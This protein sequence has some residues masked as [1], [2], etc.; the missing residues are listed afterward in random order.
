MKVFAFISFLFITLALQGTISNSLNIKG[1]KPDLLLIICYGIGLYKGEVKGL[2][3]GGFIG[4]LTDASTSH[5]L[6]PNLLSKA[7][8]GFLS[9]LLRKRV[10]MVTV[11]VNLLFILSLSM[12][13]GW[14]NYLIITIF[15]RTSSCWDVF[16]GIILPQ[17]LYSSIVGTALLTVAERYRC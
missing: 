7:T 12:L 15:L 13:D 17:S 5:L 11:G 9:G 16:Q 6:G 1:I 2:I 10:F 3:L 14:L 4:L 8:V